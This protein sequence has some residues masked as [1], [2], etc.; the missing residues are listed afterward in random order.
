[1]SVIEFKKPAAEDKERY[2]TGE[3]FCLQCKH[4]WIATAPAGEVELECPECHTMKGLF[5]WPC[6]PA[7]ESLRRECQCGNQLFYIQPYGHLCANCG[8]YQDYDDD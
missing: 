5:R 3:A 8:I 7:E 2:M 1:M 6:A 4:E